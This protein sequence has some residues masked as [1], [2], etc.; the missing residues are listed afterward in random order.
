MVATPIVQPQVL[1]SR[2]E[3]LGVASPQ[4]RVLGP[5]YSNRI[6][7]MYYD[8]VAQSQILQEVDCVWFSDVLSLEAGEAPSS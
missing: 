4:A 3:A 2:A 1:P 6:L 8:Y 5:V 7:Y